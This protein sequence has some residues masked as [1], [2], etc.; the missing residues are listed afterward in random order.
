MFAAKNVMKENERYIEL[1]H[2]KY[3]E[4]IGHVKGLFGC[5]ISDE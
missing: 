4:F 1:T 3:E 5:Y 2:K